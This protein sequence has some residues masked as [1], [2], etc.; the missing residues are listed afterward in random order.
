MKVQD[1]AIELIDLSVGYRQLPILSNLHIGLKKG[2]MVCMVGKNGIGKS[3]LLRSIA[4]IQSILG[5]RI[6]IHNHP[7]TSYSI[8]KLARTLSMVLT[9]RIFAGNLRVHELVSLGRHPYTN[10]LGTLSSLDREKIHWALEISGS[11]PVRDKKIHELSDGQFQKV[12]IARALAQDGD[13]IL[14]DEPTAHLDL[15]NKISILKLLKDLCDQT[16]KTILMATHELEYTIQ[17]ADR[18]WILL[19][20]DQ[21]ISGIPED[22]ML[23]RTFEKLV[24]HEAVDFDLSTGRFSISHEKKWYCNLEGDPAGRFWTTNALH[25][26]RWEVV[27]KE[28]ETRILVTEE[29]GSY[30]WRIFIKDREDHCSTMEEV[31]NSL[32]NLTYS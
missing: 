17:I 22:L 18:I 1:F 11:L 13:I 6:L 16:G 7:L 27:E 5:G 21:L 3:T 14:L 19:R 2:E 23:N 12:L 8:Q 10:W 15:P 4:G 25:R 31:I 9:D 32:K 29:N 20:Q 30:S 24:D 26:M 28:V